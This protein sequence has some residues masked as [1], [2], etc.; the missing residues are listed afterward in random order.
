MHGIA[1]R[2]LQTAGA[3]MKTNQ[4]SNIKDQKA[5]LKIKYGNI[6]R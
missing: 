1:E 5:K 6:Q 3:G 4:K 2:Q